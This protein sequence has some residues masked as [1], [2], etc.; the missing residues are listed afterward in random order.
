MA[1]DQKSEPTTVTRPSDPAPAPPRAEP[2]SQ[3]SAA[4]LTAIF[5]GGNVLSTGLRFVGGILTAQVVA[6][7]TLGM[8]NGVSLVLGYLTFFQL[9]IINGLNRELPYHI[10]AGH[11]EKALDLASVTQAWSLIVG[12]AVAVVLLVIAAWQGMVGNWEL[13]AGFATVAFAS[14]QYYFAQFYL[15][16]TFR[17]GG[18]FA[19][20]AIVNVAHN[21]FAIVMIAF[22]WL[23]GFYGLCL[24]QLGVAIF[25]AVL[26]WIWRP[27]KVG[28]KWDWPLFRHLLRIGFPIMV[29]GQI[30]QWWTVFDATLVLAHL[31]KQ[32][33]GLYT[34]ATVTSTTFSQLYLSTS[35]V[36]YPRMAS[37]YGRTGRLDD[38]L[39]LSIKPTLALSAMML[40][41][42]VV[43]WFLM[44]TV[45]RIVLPNYVEGVQA[46]RWTLVATA[47]MGLSPP[48]N[49]F[50]VVRRLELYCAANV[51]GLTSYYLSLRW[52]GQ[53]HPTLETFPKAMAIGYVVYLSLCFIFI[54]VLLR[55][56]RRSQARGCTT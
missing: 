5:T 7:A 34:L 48:L 18:D 37:Q 2:A 22:V 36:I 21:A 39:S 25:Q 16:V 49:I 35:Q 43:G 9:G 3:R 1:T 8:F 29:V 41:S 52:L 31:G 28:L 47:L 27:L 55:K 44:P 23:V 33:L 13:A 42:A 51:A 6:P 40:G 4:K 10:G 56:E 45:A 26:L 50:T 14:F 11:R 30:W 20:L 32:G 15:Q 53:G 38:L 19:R 54:Y 17:T 46:A 24:R 12:S